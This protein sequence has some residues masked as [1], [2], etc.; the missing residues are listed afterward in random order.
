[1][2]NNNFN[3]QLAV[4]VESSDDAI[5]SKNLDGIIISWNK[6]TEKLYGC[7]AKR[8]IGQSIIK[9]FPP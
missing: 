9:I 5:L 1:V 4:I 2:K 7:S 3:F 6:T 8:I